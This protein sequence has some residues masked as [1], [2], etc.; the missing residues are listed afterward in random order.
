MNFID[1]LKESEINDL[2]IDDETDEYYTAEDL[3]G[4]ADFMVDTRKDYLKVKKE[5]MRMEIELMKESLDIIDEVLCLCD[6]DIKV[7]VFRTLWD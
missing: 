1:K 5:T 4:V 7:E 6:R 2:P 3:R